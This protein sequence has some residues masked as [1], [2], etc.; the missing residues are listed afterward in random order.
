MCVVMQSNKLILVLIVFLLVFSSVHS[1]LMITGF[2]VAGF[3]GDLSEG[4]SDVV[5]GGGEDFFP[6]N[7]SEIAELGVPREYSIDGEVY[8]LNVSD[9]G[10]F[11]KGRDSGKIIPVQLATYEDDSYVNSGFSFNLSAEGGPWNGSLTA[12]IVDPSGPLIEV[13]KREGISISEGQSQ[14]VMLNWGLPE[15]PRDYLTSAGEGSSSLVVLI[16]GTELNGRKTNFA[17]IYNNNLDERNRWG[18]LGLQFEDYLKAGD[19]SNY[20]RTESDD[21][22]ALWFSDF[23]LRNEPFDSSDSVVNAFYRRIGENSNSAVILNS[24][25]KF[26]G[27]QLLM[28]KTDFKG[29]ENQ[30][31]GFVGPA[32]PVSG[33][34]FIGVIRGVEAL[35]VFGTLNKDGSFNGLVLASAVPNSSRDFSSLNV[36]SILEGP[37]YVNNSSLN[38]ELIKKGP[39]FFGYIG[40]GQGPGKNN[41]FAVSVPDPDNSGKHLTLMIGGNYLSGEVSF[42]AGI[43]EL[44]SNLKEINTVT[45]FEGYEYNLRIQ[46]ILLGAVAETILSFNPGLKDNV[47]KILNPEGTGVSDGTGQDSVLPEGGLPVSGESTG[48]LPTGGLPDLTPK[49]QQSAVDDLIVLEPGVEDSLNEAVGLIQTV[50]NAFNPSESSTQSTIRVGGG[51][52]GRSVSFSTANALGNLAIRA[53]NSIDPKKVVD[54]VNAQLRI[55]YNNKAK[56]SVLNPDPVESAVLGEKVGSIA[57]TQ[58]SP[59]NPL[60]VAANII[61]GN[62]IVF[63]RTKPDHLPRLNEEELVSTLRLDEGLKQIIKTDYRSK[64]DNNDKLIFSNQHSPDYSYRSALLNYIYEFHGFYRKCLEG[65]RGQQAECL[66]EAS[67]EMAIFLSKAIESADK[68]GINKESPYYKWLMGLKENFESKIPN[69]LREKGFLPPST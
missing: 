8:F 53:I 15:G 25:F 52:S 29:Y 19:G 24:L 27:A 13:G 33:S 14:E 57:L 17:F 63:N 5:S 22:I 45:R 6:L 38:A 48:V 7:Y 44:P 47:E 42:L 26:N 64:I 3:Q 41:Y 36:S 9:E 62:G 49:E 35:I 37:V 31:S 30:V 69:E 46:R 10:S 59:E 60:I 21:S 51:G 66:D 40:E 68:A 16:T 11:F 32:N 12:S 39:G 50:N 34:D 28:A 18:L 4:S 56:Q 43:A 58:S 2:V 55:A 23:S 61:A 20:F 67:K 1:E 65:K 54:E